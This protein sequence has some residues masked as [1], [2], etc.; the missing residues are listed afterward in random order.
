MLSPEGTDAHIM[1]IDDN[2]SVVDI[3]TR[4]LTSR[5]YRVTS[6]GDGRSGWNRL[7]R[8][9]EE[10]AMPDLLL[11]DLMLP[12][13]DGLGVMRRIRS[14]KR[15]ARMPVIIL[16]VRDETEVR[17]EALEA[18]ANDYLTKPFVTVEL[19]TRVEN[20][21]SWKMAEHLQQ[22]K[23]KHLVEAGQ[24]LLSTLDIGQVLQH[25][26]D[27]AMLGL[28]AEG[29]SVWIRSTDGSLICRAVSGISADQLLGWKIP[30]GQGIAGWVLQH[31]ESVIITDVNADPRFYRA[32][33]EQTGFHNRD[34]VAVP[35]LVREQSIGVLEAVNKEQGTFSSSDL[36]WMEILA[37]MAAAS[38]ANARLFKMLQQ[39]TIELQERNEELDAFAHTVAHDLSNPL[40]FIL[41]YA[42]VLLS[43]YKTLPDEEVYKHLHT[44]VRT[45]YRMDNIIDELLLLAQVRKT[46]V[47]LEPIN[48]DEVVSAALE[49]L[50]YFIEKQSAEINRPSKWPPALGYG[51]WVEEVW[52]NYIHNAIKYGG[53]PPHVKL[54]AT[55]LPDDRV[56]FWVCDNGEGIP[57]EEQAQLFTPFK[58][59]KQVR[60]KGH[61]LG[62]SIVRRIVEKLNGQVGVR[63][64]LGQGSSFYFILPSA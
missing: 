37:P 54:G 5:G 45:S 60:S 63:S 31:K 33:S 52:L 48:M 13:L 17:L 2:P 57:E 25:V 22:Q 15:F 3:L 6:C 29:A 59:L 51:P 12:I 20:I 41:G 40:S 24:V 19:I 50:T 46:D 8:S 58:R 42:D 9:A 11:L 44:I 49:Q 28:G 38:F 26:M 4:I 39:R 10:N 1:V 64:E 32:V 16:T 43:D 62:L 55:R 56:C 61:G 47:E 35:L 23:M 14:D 30:P 27:I 7:L 36:A 53:S 34:I 18:G 21:L